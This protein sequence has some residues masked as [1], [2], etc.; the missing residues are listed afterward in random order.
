MKVLTFLTLSLCCYAQNT[1]FGPTQAAP[2]NAQLV[3]V[4]VSVQDS[5]EPGGLQIQSVKFDGQSIPL[6]PRDIHGYRAKGSFQVKPGTYQLT[7]V[8]NRDKSAW[9]RNVRHEADVKV[10]PRDLWIQVHIE[11]ENVSIQ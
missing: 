11:G 1:Y 3:R 5:S 6:K 7:W 4:E 10:D 9:P 2:G 8:V